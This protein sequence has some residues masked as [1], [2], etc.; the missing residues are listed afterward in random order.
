MK[1]DLN[2]SCRTD[3]GMAAMLASFFTHGVHVYGDK[4]GVFGCVLWSLCYMRY[5][6]RGLGSGRWCNK[7]D[8]GLPL[9]H[10]ENCS[11]QSLHLWLIMVSMVD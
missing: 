3:E 6:F 7:G 8:L 1:V 4:A 10:Y 9:M 2:D 11:K 5:I